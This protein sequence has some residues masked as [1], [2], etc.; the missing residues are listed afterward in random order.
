MAVKHN[1]NDIEYKIET[2]ISQLIQQFIY[3]KPKS[4]SLTLKLDLNFDE[5]PIND[6]NESI[7]TNEE[8]VK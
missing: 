4:V 2:G 5:N 3:T 7:E 8:S 1:Q 6:L